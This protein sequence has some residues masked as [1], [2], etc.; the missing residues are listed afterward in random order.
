MGI[1]IHKEAR[2]GTLTSI[3]LEQFIKDGGNINDPDPARGFTPLAVAAKTG[4]LSV[5]KALIEKKA[6]VNKKSRYGCTPLYFAANASKNRVEVVR[7]LLDAGADVNATDPDCDNETPIMVAITQ[8][9]DPK[10]VSMLYNSGASL[11]VTN[12]KGE[13]ARTMAE[14]S[15]NP[16]IQRAIQPPGQQRP[17]LA[18]AVNALV[19]LVLFILAYVNSGIITGVAKGVVSNLY[20]I[21]GSTEPDPELSKAIENPTTVDDFTKNVEQYVKDYN[22]GH[23]FSTGSKYLQDVAE[24]AVHLKDDPNNHLKKPE[25]IDGLVK[26]ALFQPIF[27]CDDSGSME[28]KLK[29]SN[30][31]RMDAQRTLVK[32]MA[33]IATRLVPDGHGAHLRFINKKTPTLND[34]KESQIDEKMKF[35]PSGGT[36]I[37]TQLEQQILKPYIYDVL[38]SGNTLDRPYLILTIT[39]GSPNNEDPKAFR[40][41]V[42]KCGQRLTDRQYEQEAVTFL[43]SQVGDDEGADAFL[44]SLSGDTAIDR[45]LYRTSERLHEKYSDLRDN[46]EDLEEWLFNILMKPITG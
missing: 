4:Q 27:F 20:H 30:E 5:V 39:D 13:N 12:S 19:S 46:E 23:F 25:Q 43:V 3:R 44:D 42:V 10:V 45:V 17:G 41:A 2:E 8:A 11:S 15:N 24:K 38:D 1:D 36:Q 34:L 18:E 21:M 22:L 9:R 37:G 33:S 7:A 14:T 32:R 26:L 31:N 35:S 40:N 16:S 28:A 6:D 29:D